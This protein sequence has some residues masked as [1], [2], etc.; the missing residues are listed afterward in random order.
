MVHESL[1]LLS[2]LLHIPERMI[3]V[4]EL[5]VPNLYVKRE[6]NLSSQPF[7]ADKVMESDLVRWLLLSGTNHPQIA[8]RARRNLKSEDFRDPI[9]KKLFDLYFALFDEEKPRD[10]LAITIQMKEEEEG[11]FLS[12]L[13]EKRVSLERV[14]AGVTEAIQKL[15]IRNWMEEREELKAKLQDPT[16]S[17]EK[18]LFFV[19]K[20][21]ELKKSP[22][23]VLI[24]SKDLVT[25]TT[26]KPNF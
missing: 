7:N 24:E 11:R 23:Q 9:C 12:E 3:G 18:A 4:D 22:P 19:K 1:R 8:L 10:L 21:D 13:L 16:L 15:L 14:D 6:E 5:V 2:Q 26:S 25:K 17:E 20:F